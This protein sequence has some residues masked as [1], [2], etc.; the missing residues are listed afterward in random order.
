MFKIKNKLFTIKYAYIDAF[1]SNENQLVFGLQIK[2]TGKDKFPNQ[3]YADTFDLFFPDNELLFNSE[4]LLKINP[5]EIEKWEDIVERKIEWKDYPENEEEPHALFYV[6][7]HTGVYNAKIEFKNIA[8]KIIVH[9][10]ASCNIYAGEVFSDNLP[11]EIETEVDFFGILC[12]KDNE[13]QCR[14]KLKQFLNLDNLKF[15]QN[16]YNVSLMVPKN[17]NLETNLLVLGNY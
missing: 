15:I 16:K 1:I 9:V 12:G 8:N 11:L 13:E 6:Y 17:T 14:K 7:E 3:D 10:I 2:A 4:I 5:N